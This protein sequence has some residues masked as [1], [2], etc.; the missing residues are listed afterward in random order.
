MTQWDQ[1]KPVWRLLSPGGSI[2]CYHGIST[3]ACPAAGIA[4]V[5][6]ETFRN[7]LAATRAVSEI[8][9]LSELLGRHEH[10]QPTAGLTAVTFDD[11]Y[12]SLP[13]AMGNLIVE[14]SLP[15]TLFVVTEA[16]RSGVPFWWDRLDDVVRLVPHDRWRQFEDEL[17]L[18]ESYRT[19]Q[20]LEYGPVRPLRQWLLREHVGRWPHTFEAPLGKLEAE[21]GST[22]HQR[23]MTLDEVQEF[24][25]NPM[26]DV[27]V[28]T[29]SHAVLPLLPDEEALREVRDSFRTLRERIPK[30]LA[31]LAVPFGLYDHRTARLS[32][33]AGM[34]TFLALRN[35][36]L[37][38]APEGHGL[39]RICIT[40]HEKSWKLRLRLVGAVE[41]LL[42]WRYPTGGYPLLPSSRA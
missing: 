25:H 35:R 31:V 6:L 38:K 14:E 42:P 40:A 7:T 29:A 3:A 27:A 1:L 37:R 30:C 2:L 13:A 41:Q 22:T 28:H 26:V 5:T 24:S 8:V 21:V 32:R 17:G 12:A 16:S 15:I 20:P 9:P 39:P 23:P 4:H 18:P 10:G 33:A 11:A 34:S 36:T 19:G